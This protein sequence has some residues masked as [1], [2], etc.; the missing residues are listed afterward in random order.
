M[1]SIGRLE[2]TSA[3]G[4]RLPRE[5]IRLAP[6]LVPLRR[7]WADFKWVSALV[8][9][10]GGGGLV[11]VFAI[12]AKLAGGLNAALAAGLMN[13]LLTPVLCVLAVPVLILPAVFWTRHAEN[14]RVKR[15]R[16]KHPDVVADAR[17]AAVLHEMETTG[18]AD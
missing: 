8:V 12:F 13:V 6:P 7:V 14:R 1:R 2:T 10:I 5:I 4:A 9:G 11:V 17:V 15:W 3:D 16:Q 18:R